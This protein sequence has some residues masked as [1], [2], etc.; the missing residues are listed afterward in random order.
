VVPNE[1]GRA[2]VAYILA[3]RQVPIQGYGGTP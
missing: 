3:R 1:R 2:L